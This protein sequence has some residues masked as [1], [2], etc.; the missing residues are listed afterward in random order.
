MPISFSTSALGFSE[1]AF[2]FIAPLPVLGLGTSFAIT[3]K[4]KLNQ[5]IEILYL[6]FADFL[7]PRLVFYCYSSFGIV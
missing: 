6:G 1:E 5:S 2:E 4:L 7:I 3:P